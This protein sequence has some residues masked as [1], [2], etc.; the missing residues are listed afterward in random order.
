MKVTILADIKV[1][2]IKYI[3]NRLIIPVIFRK[4]LRKLN[5]I[6]RLY[7][8]VRLRDDID[9]W[10][11]AKFNTIWTDATIN[12]PY[13]IDLK[14]K[15]ALPDYFDKLED[16]R[17][18]PILTK[19]LYRENTDKFQRK[20]PARFSIMTG[21]SSGDPLRLY[22]NDKVS[23]AVN[24]LLGR[25][26]ISLGIADKKILIWGHHHLYGKGWRFVL[27]ILKRKIQD[28]ILNNVRLNGYD[29]SDDYLLEIARKYLDSR[30]VFLIAYSTTLVRFIELLY[31]RREEFD[32]RLKGIVGSAGPL[33]KSEREQLSAIFNCEVLMEYGSAEFGAMAYT[34]ATTSSYK[35]F[36]HSHLMETKRQAGGSDILVTS[37]NGDYTPLIRYE[38]GDIG[39]AEESEMLP[40]E[41]KD[42]IG[43][44]SDYLTFG[45][46]AK[47]W[48]V[49][50]Y[51]VVKQYSSN[52][53][54]Q[55]VYSLDVLDIYHDGIEEE[56]YKSIV[57]K[58]IELAPKLAEV[59][60]DFK[61]TSKFRQAQSGKF[62]R[63]IHEG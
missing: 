51:D 33:T 36:W 27:N 23:P 26:Q 46:G 39:L 24:Q 5:L 59:R 6:S 54:I 29:V 16:I 41:F 48:F 28:L 12:V 52:T 42:I 57:D 1:M 34:S 22:Y 47:I 43:R 44:N 11:L 9:T 63:V 53:K 55:I 50:I 49:L 40:T 2:W 15:H 31:D 21:G 10:R 45:N 30:E 13:Y 61:R 14:Q 32:F 58:L 62:I 25:Q 60:I 17:R 18:I 20:E 4:R 7:D 3:W 35:V 38:I 8:E 56:K 19:A 37:L